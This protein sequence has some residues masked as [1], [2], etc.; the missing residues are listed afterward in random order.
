MHA[1]DSEQAA[2]ALVKTFVEEFERFPGAD[3]ETLLYVLSRSGVSRENAW[4]L[5]QFVPTAFCRVAF[6]HSGLAFPLTYISLHPQTKAEARR[7]FPDQPLYMA[8]RQVAEA[9]VAEGL[10]HERVLPIAELSAEFNALRQLGSFNVT[11]ALASAPK[12]PGRWRA[13]LRRLPAGPKRERETGQLGGVQ[14]SE[15]ILF[16]YLPQSEEFDPDDPLAMILAAHGFQANRQNGQVLANAKLPAFSAHVFNEQNQG[17]YLHI[18]LDVRMAIDADTVIV[19]SFGGG[20]STLAEAVDQALAS[21]TMNS[22]HPVLAVYHGEEEGV[23]V[24]H[25]QIRD[26]PWRMVSGN[27]LI[28]TADSAPVPASELLGELTQEVF[29]TLEEMVKQLTLDKPLHWLRF[30]YGHTGTQDACEV[31]LDNATWEAAQD[32]LRGLASPNPDF[33][34]S[35][36]SFALLQRE[37]EGVFDGMAGTA[38]T[39]R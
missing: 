25:W 3:E 20:G 7:S 38:D 26:E 27:F 21:F 29:S 1:D 34:Y 24:E 23:E 6:Q 17:T 2:E 5:I 39:G 16:E 15:P 32:R 31:L 30:F 28:R 9:L 14:F 33:F 8:A 35:V 18:Q 19:E 37:T 12:T 11:E 13:L 4:Y 22:L 10:L 36:R